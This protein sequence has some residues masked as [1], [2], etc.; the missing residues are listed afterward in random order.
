MDAHTRAWRTPRLRETMYCSNICKRTTLV[1]TPIID[2]P[3]PSVTI[4][5]YLTQPKSLY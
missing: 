5:L 4:S 3:L 1:Y 2:K